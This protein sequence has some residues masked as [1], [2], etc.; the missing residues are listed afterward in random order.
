MTQRTAE[1][2]HTAV[3]LQM[4]DK[5]IAKNYS[6][7]FILLHYTSNYVTSLHFKFFTS[8]HFW[9]FRLHPPKTLHFSSLI[10]IYD[11]EG[12]VTSASGANWFHSVTVLFTA[13]F[14]DICS[15]ITALIV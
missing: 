11:V 12:K 2:I 15:W 13:V 9:K 8:L 3:E 7:H 1:N 10:K 4:N 14:A 5:Y 6:L